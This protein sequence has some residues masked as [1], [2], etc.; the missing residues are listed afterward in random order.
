MATDT[1]PLL[2]QSSREQAPQEDSHPITLRACHSPWINQKLLFSFRTILA[3]YLTSVAGV[4][5]KY[6]LESEDDHSGW[7]VPFQFSTVS[8]VL[9]WVYHLV[10]LAWTGVHTFEP[11]ARELAEEPR[12]SHVQARLAR[13][14]SPP[15]RVS[16]IQR[17]GY[18]MFYTVSHVFPL[19]NGLMYWTV[20][21]PSGHGG[22]VA[23]KF[24]HHHHGVG[25]STGIF[26]DPN[27]GLFEEDDIKAFSILNIWSITAIIAF[28]EM[29]FLNS[30]RRQ[31]PV[32]G[33]V[34]GTMIASILYLA[35]AGIGKLATNHWGLFFLDPHLMGNS[36]WAAIA[37]AVGFVVANPVVFTYIHGLI[38]MR[39]SIT[40]SH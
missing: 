17:L 26:Y 33:H 11:N 19:L 31:S 28:I 16:N 36:T 22:F 8:F 10:T 13:F 15:H 9:Q 24:P 6:K 40:A 32:T 4:A 2:P 20:L 21:V 27:K 37:A 29:A 5:L 12:C 38:A 25:N 7:R 35:W 39:E 18:S 14:F 1:T 34:G 3:S 30:I 23:P